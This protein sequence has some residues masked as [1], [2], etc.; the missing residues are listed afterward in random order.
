MRKLSFPYIF[1]WQDILVSPIKH[2]VL[3][4]AASKSDGK[5]LK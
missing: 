3:K 4:G 1:L 2:I 5:R